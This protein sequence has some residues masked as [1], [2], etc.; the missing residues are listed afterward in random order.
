MNPIKKL[1]SA[2]ANLFI[3]PIRFYRKFISPWTPRSCRYC[4]SCSQYAIEAYK[5]HGVFWGSVLTA[6]RI[7][8]CNP[9]SEGGIDHVP[10]KITREYFKKKKKRHEKG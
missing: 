6:W 7:L 4:P 8:R 3:A 10:Q 5:M 9:W 1:S 2:A